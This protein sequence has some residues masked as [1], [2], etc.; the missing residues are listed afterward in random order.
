MTI[1]ITHLDV[2][3]GIHE[4]SRFILRPVPY[5]TVNSTW[6]F[7]PPYCEFFECDEEGNWLKEEAISETEEYHSRYRRLEPMWLYLEKFDTFHFQNPVAWTPTTKA[8]L[9]ELQHFYET[10]EF[11]DINIEDNAA[12]VLK[13]FR[14]LGLYWG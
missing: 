6:K 12:M 8:I 1:E 5:V 14:A 2:R 7:V 3:E 11:R 4:T 9:T 10:G 13:H